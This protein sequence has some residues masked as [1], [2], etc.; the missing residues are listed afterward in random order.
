MNT[1]QN[2]LDKRQY[3]YLLQHA[4]RQRTRQEK[5]ARADLAGY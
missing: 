3:P 5:Y 1:D 2:A 4:N